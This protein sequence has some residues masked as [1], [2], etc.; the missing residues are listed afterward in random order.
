MFEI[1]LLDFEDKGARWLYPFEDVGKYQFAKGSRSATQEQVAFFERTVRQLDRPLRIECEPSVT[2]KTQAQL[3]VE[4]KHARSW[5]LEKSRFLRSE[6]TFDPASLD[7]GPLLHED[8]QEYMRS[9]GLSDMEERFAAQWASNSE[10]GEFIKGHRIVIAEAGLSPYEG[11]VVRDPALFDESSGKERRLRHL[12]TRM[13]FVQ[14]V[15]S[16][17]GVERPLLYRAL[18]C[19]GPLEPRNKKRA[20]ISATFNREVAEALFGERDTTR[21]VALY[22]QTVALERL[23]MTHMETWQ[24]NRPFREAEAVLIADPANLAF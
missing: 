6:Q 11:K 8:L 1:E 24:L 23:F 2:Q 18:S 7:G 15:F 13:A 10:S 9:H 5:L 14:E 21:T 12:V 4:R 17:R 19:S 3:A 16:Q 20:L 22:R